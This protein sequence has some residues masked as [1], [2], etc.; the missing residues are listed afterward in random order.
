MR[1]SR[2][3]KDICGSEKLIWCLYSSCCNCSS[4]CG[5]GDRLQ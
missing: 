3:V 4:C 2:L 1:L 5:L